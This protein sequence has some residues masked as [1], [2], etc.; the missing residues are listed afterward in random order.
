[1]MLDGSM[2]AYLWILAGLLLL[3]AEILLPG[4]FLL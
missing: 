2:P 1:M 3:G 4:V